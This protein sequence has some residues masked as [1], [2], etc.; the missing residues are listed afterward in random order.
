MNSMKS[1]AYIETR[2]LGKRLDA[3]RAVV[4]SVE[5]AARDFLSFHPAIAAEASATADSVELVIGTERGFCGDLNQQLQRHVA[6]ERSG[7]TA[8]RHLVVVGRKL[9][10]LFEDDARVAAWLA[11]AETAEEV[12]AVLNRVVEE[13]SGLQQRYGPLSVSIVYCGAEQPDTIGLLPPFR[14][15]PAAPRF[16][17]RPVL[18]LSPPELLLAITDQYLF[19]ALNEIL[20]A[21]LMEENHRRVMHLDGAVSHL[22]RQTEQLGRRLNAL[23]QEEIIEEIEV[24][25]LSAGG[26][27]PDESA[28]R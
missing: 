11:G 25:L 18:N 28:A 16:A 4:S 23:R 19:A 12:A 26:P 13:L 1:L 9:H 27:S 2:K 21:A 20:Y 14:D 17:Y 6:A 22:D 15:E 24:I 8:P 3:Q 5:A 10:A 7:G